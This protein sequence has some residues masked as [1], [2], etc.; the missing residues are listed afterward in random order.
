MGRPA[1]GQIVE[2]CGKRG[3]VYA[4]RFRVPGH[5]RV[6]ETLR[7]VTTR[8]EAETELANRLADVR[9]GLW[10][11]PVADVPELTVE[12]PTFHTFASSVS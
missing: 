6:Y 5:G 11:A 1:R 4:L 3:R 7:D 10:R 9:R 12:E 8:A 2:R